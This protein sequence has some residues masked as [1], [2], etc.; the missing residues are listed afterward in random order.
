MY[1]T[2]VSRDKI[3]GPMVVDPNMVL[4][5]T[6][7][8]PLTSGETVRPNLHLESQYGR[9]DSDVWVLDTQLNGDAKPKRVRLEFGGTYA[10][11]HLRLHSLGNVPCDIA[12][13]AAHNT[14]MLTLP[15]DF[16]GMI[17]VRRSSYGKMKPLPL[18]VQQ[19][20]DVGG[21]MRCFVGDISQIG[22][23]LRSA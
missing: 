6:L 21:D 5:E 3:Q 8:P 4:P 14:T 12:V 7:L 1:T 11:V 19:I 18:R 15:H 13:D 10:G 20:S 9:V 2:S 17:T 16:V 22:E 23:G